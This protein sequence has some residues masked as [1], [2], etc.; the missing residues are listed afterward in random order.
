MTA[1]VLNPP[2][3]AL[4]PLWFDCRPPLH[5]HNCC[6]SQPTIRISPQ[7]DVAGQDQPWF[8]CSYPH[9]DWTPAT[10]PGNGEDC[11]AITAVAPALMRR[12]GNLLDSSHSKP[13]FPGA[14]CNLP[15]AIETWH[16]QAFSPQSSK[17]FSRAR[18]CSCPKQDSYNIHNIL[19]PSWIHCKTFSAQADFQA[20]EFCAEW[21]L[22]HWSWSSWD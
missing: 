18:G 14:L 13:L 21:A 11:E 8:A 12:L 9:L 10:E 5:S 1:K 20:L 3:L 6:S 16:M 7:S 19:S 22:L 15:C 2:P 17:T 4:L